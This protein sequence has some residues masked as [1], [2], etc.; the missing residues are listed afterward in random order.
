MSSPVSE[1]LEKHLLYFE[2][3]KYIFLI[4]SRRFIISYWVFERDL[5]SW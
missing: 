2:S 5:V 4:P 3:H 1:R